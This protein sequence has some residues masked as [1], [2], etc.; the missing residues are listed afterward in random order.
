MRTRAT[1]AIFSSS[2][3]AFRR[4]L[5]RE[6]RQTARTEQRALTSRCPRQIGSDDPRGAVVALVGSV[7]GFVHSV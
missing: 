6:T 7:Q 1:A 5:Y 3:R 2:L 4:S